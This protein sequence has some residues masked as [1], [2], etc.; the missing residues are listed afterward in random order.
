MTTK[1][2]FVRE[3]SEQSLVP[4][5]IGR[6][7]YEALID[8]IAEGLARD[9][10]VVVIGLGTF[11]LRHHKGFVSRVNGPQKVITIPDR[12]LIRFYPCDDVYQRVVQ[13]AE[14]ASTPSV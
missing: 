12:K 3:I 7:V 13:A 2:S 11:K 9:G 4:Q 1:H 5:R 10:R 8:V 6:A 14:A